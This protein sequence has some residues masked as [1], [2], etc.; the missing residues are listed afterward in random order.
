MAEHIVPEA[1]REAGEGGQSQ[2][3]RLCADRNPLP[4]RAAPDLAE[5]TE[6][7]LR[8]SQGGR[9]EPGVTLTWGKGRGTVCF[10]GPLLA[11]QYPSQ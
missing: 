4:S 6:R 10:N 11:S 9:E 3:A 8:P 2:E 5:G 7:D 1:S